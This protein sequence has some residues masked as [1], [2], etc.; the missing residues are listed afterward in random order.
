LWET[1]KL[2]SQ[3]LEELGMTQAE[4]CC[5]LVRAH[6][7]SPLQESELSR[8]IAGKSDTPK[9]HRTLEDA[10][11]LL[12]RELRRRQ[13]VVS[14]A[15]EAL[16]GSRPTGACPAGSGRRSRPGCGGTS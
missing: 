11:S 3:L 5:E 12:T 14:E 2:V 1:R 16:E 7:G 6:R 15:R 9:A 8:Y 4:L 13:K 10:V